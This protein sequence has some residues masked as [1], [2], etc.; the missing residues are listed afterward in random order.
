M[1]CQHRR[2]ERG[3]NARAGKHGASRRRGSGPSEIADELGGL[4][5]GKLH[6]A[7]LAADALARALGAA[8]RE[9]AFVT[10][11]SE[12][13]RP[14]TLVAMSGGVDSAVAA[15]ECARD[16]RDR[17]GHARAVGGPRERRRAQLLL[18]LR[19]G[20]G[21]RA[22]PRD[23][24]AALH[25][26]PARRVPGRRGRAVHRRLRGRGDPEPV[27]RLQRPR[28]PRRDARPRR[29]P[30]LRTARHRPLRADRRARPPRRAAAAR[31]RRPRQG[32]DVHAGG[33]RAELAGAD[34]LSARRADQVGGQADRRRRGPAG[35]EQ[36]RLAGPVLPGRHRPRPLPRPPRR[37][38]RRT[39]DRSSTPAARCSADHLGQHRFTVGQR[40]GL[41]L[42][43][44]GEPLYVLDKDAAPAR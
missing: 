23:G 3:G 34:A 8:V 15:L 20:A 12:P 37:P 24:P 33:A 38:R 2:R 28:P 26:R 22:G 21:A 17:G 18:G 27:R 4:S 14:G 30:R 39:R 41:G 43:A 11:A 40:R 29:P 36:G 25:D 32:S 7:E 1:R 13:A 42:A 35:R 6:A 9:R 5:P 16:G 10:N 44:P 31:R 19:G